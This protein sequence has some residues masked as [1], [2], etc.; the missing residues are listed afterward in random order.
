MKIKTIIPVFAVLVALIVAIL[1]LASLEARDGG[2]IQAQSVEQQKVEKSKL[3]LT[4][5]ITTACK[6][7]ERG[8]IAGLTEIVVEVP[9]V[10]TQKERSEMT[11]Y[12]RSKGREPYI[13]KRSNNP[14]ALYAI[15]KHP[16]ATKDELVRES[17]YP[18]SWDQ[19]KGISFM[20]I[21]SVREFGN[22]ARGLVWFGRDGQ[23]FG[24]YEILLINT[25]DG[26]KVFSLTLPT[27]WSAQY[28]QAPDQ[29]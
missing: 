1:V 25:E 2:H 14:N 4:D 6:M 16:A 29:D 13:P 20:K 15:P 11:K 17:I 27:R 24:E 19:N 5:T 21:R 3:S 9:E 7:A 23:F 22:E 28:A 8:D 10:Y 26:W 12:A 18:V